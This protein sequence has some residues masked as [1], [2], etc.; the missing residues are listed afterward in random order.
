MIFCQ[1]IKLTSDSSGDSI[2]SRI[3]KTCHVMAIRC[4]ELEHQRLF[5]ICKSRGSPYS[6]NCMFPF[7]IWSSGTSTLLP[8]SS[9]RTICGCCLAGLPKP[10]LTILKALEAESAVENLGARQGSSGSVP[11][12]LSMRDRTRLEKAMSTLLA[13]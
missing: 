6:E 11:L 2:N 1:L 13:P 10:C 12:A 4:K 5:P 3:K 8:T 7:L 9:T